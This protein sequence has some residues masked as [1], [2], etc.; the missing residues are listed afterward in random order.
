VPLITVL[1]TRH[2][3]S[4]QRLNKIES[5][6][7]EVKNSASVDFEWLPYKGKYGPDKTKI[8]AASFC[9]NWG[10][11]IVLHISRYSSSA[12]PEK[13][14]IQ[15]ILYYLNRFPLTFGWYSTG[16][17]VYDEK[18]G[19]QKG[20]DSDLFI[21]HQ[22][23][24]YHGLPSPVELK[25]RYARLKDPNK[26][27]I[28]LCKVFEKP[29]VLK[30]VF[31]EK[32]R[33]TSLNSVSQ[34]LSSAGKYDE[35]NAGVS[36]IFSL[37]F[38]QQL[39][40]VRRDSELT[41]L[42]A[43]Y[44]NCLALRMMKVFAEYGDMDYYQTCH[45]QIGRWY[46]SKYR[47]MLESGECTVSFTPNYRLDKQ[48]TGGGHHI[49]PAKGYFIGI[50]IYELDVNGQ[51]P[52]I[53]IKNNISF[54]TLNCTCC[55]YDES[56]RISQDTIDEINEH[57]QENKILRRVEKYWTCKNRKGAYPTVLEHT[58][59]DRAKYKRLRD[60]EKGKS[61]P[62]PRLIEEYE[63]RQIGAKIFAN[64]GF[65][66]FGNEYFDFANYKVFECI[67]GE[68]RRII[69]QMQIL[70]QSEPYK[71]EVIFG[72]T[73]SVFYKDTAAAVVD[74]EGKVDNFIQ[75]CKNK[76]GATVEKK[77]V[78]INSIF[79]GKKNRFVAWTGNEKDK[80]VIK[81]LEG[82]SDL[83]PSWVRRWF[84]RVV[85]ELVKH[86]ETRFEVILEMI[87][88]A[89]DEL[90][91][92]SF[93]RKEE[94]KFTQRLAK[95]AYEYKHGVLSGRLAQM[96]N[97]GKGDLV[98]FYVTYENVYVQSKRCWRKKKTNSIK[99]ENLNLDEYKKL[100]FAKLKDSL[101]ITGFDMVA[102]EQKLL[103][104]ENTTLVSFSYPILS[105]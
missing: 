53:A 41:M 79:Y 105:A 90:E 9:T 97:K 37:P 43:Q 30:N 20:R 85:V 47:N 7:P 73:D 62:D 49:E 39:N 8:F 88:N 46:A 1:G 63:A 102:L 74:D 33:T 24:I 100:L 14:L 91:S 18:T 5:Y 101:E 31:G 38:E 95:D 21:L 10:K 48:A 42:L 58:R 93:N 96:L 64:A 59:E 40:Y 78:F 61:N 92:D 27:H 26:K 67:T 44:S 52:N 103:G 54:D 6:R 22:R 70:A 65:G 69:K 50:K 104:K 82:L 12:N 29:I 2:G 71:F 3:V 94:L 19:S 81:G 4:K 13:E 98:H 36:N 28:D 23:C 87:K 75:V 55:K 80:V 76:L 68:G 51:Y 60:E 45:T 11:R 56:A 17:V 16:I 83:N 72:F 86:P 35:L 99:P 66:L 34:A 84:E 25:N 57:L 77:T 89:F 15:R 32:Y